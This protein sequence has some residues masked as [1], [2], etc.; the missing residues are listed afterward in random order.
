MKKYIF[1]FLGLVFFYFVGTCG[2]EDRSDASAALADVPE[3]GDAPAG[4][5][6]LPEKRNANY[7]PWTADA[8]PVPRNVSRMEDANY[9]S[10][11]DS[12]LSPDYIDGINYYMKLMQFMCDARGLV[13]VVKYTEPDDPYEF[14]MQVARKHK[15]GGIENGL[16]F[17]L[18]LATES[19]SYQI[20]TSTTMEKY[21]TDGHCSD[22]EHQDMM[23]YLKEGNWDD[24]IL[25]AVG[26]IF[27]VLVDE[28][29]LSKGFGI[30][31]LGMPY[32]ADERGRIIDTGV[33]SRFFSSDTTST[34]K[35]Q[36][37]YDPSKSGEDEEF[38][39]WDYFY[40]F[41]FMSVSIGIVILAKIFGVG[42]G[43]GGGSSGGSWGGGS[44]SSG[45]SW[46]SSGGG[47]YG[48]GGAGG[49][50]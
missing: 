44:S 16:G 3:K 10:D 12:I 38:T 20:V 5:A 41:L 24:A 33:T 9:V 39:F 29:E 17:V 32:H 8:L 36:Y 15:V 14:T 26:D 18:M 13:V 11:P 46:G 43:G 21:L 2:D 35:A 27:E 7:H 42:G 47:S 19:R 31:S 28:P 6:D 25:V 45:G 22:I 40:V 37:V 4:V 50:F 1:I 30:D 49:R 34:N 48:G 23:P